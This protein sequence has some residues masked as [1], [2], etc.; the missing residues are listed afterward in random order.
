MPCFSHRVVA[1]VRAT[2]AGFVL[3]LVATLCGCGASGQADAPST[4]RQ[5]QGA[6]VAQGGGRSIRA[7]GIAR[8]PTM[9]TQAPTVR[10]HADSAL[11]PSRA[12]GAAQADRTSAGSHAPGV[13]G[14]ASGPGSFRELADGEC[15]AGATYLAGSTSAPSSS[16]GSQAKASAPEASATQA[17]LMVVKREIDVL[18]NLS[19]PASLRSSVD[20]LVEILTRLQRLYLAGPQSSLGAAQGAIAVT[21][22]QATGAAIV[23]GLPVCA[24]LTRSQQASP[25][26]VGAPSG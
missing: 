11:P 21:E 18:R 8:A 2:I 6:S 7:P 14:D 10:A 23:V 25:R 26:P 24:A 15:G 12:T 22:Q 19:A 17:K 13:A 4:H 3:V 9:R 1:I 16:R 5:S 20:Q